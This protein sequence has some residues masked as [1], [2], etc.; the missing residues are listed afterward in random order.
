MFLH[1][2]GG[3]WHIM[4]TVTTG[5]PRYTALSSIKTPPYLFLYAAGFSAHSRNYL[6]THPHRKFDEFHS[7]I[8][9]P[10][11]TTLITP[12]AILIPNSTKSL[13]LRLF[14]VSDLEKNPFDKSISATNNPP[15][16]ENEKGE[17]VDL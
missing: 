2:V 10:A 5:S 13:L 1:I 16:M 12:F 4:S 8:S 15:T 3:V 11:S 14:G 9:P 7:E 17:I 6:G